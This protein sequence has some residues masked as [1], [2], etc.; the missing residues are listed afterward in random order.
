MAPD[1]LEWDTCLPGPEVDFRAIA[2]HPVRVGAEADGQIVLLC[3]DG[4]ALFVSFDRTEDPTAPGTTVDI[5]LDWTRVAGP[6]A[7]GVT[8]LV[9][10]WT[11]GGGVLQLAP[12]EPDPGADAPGARTL[13]GPEFGLRVPPRQAAV[14]IDRLLRL[15][16]R[17]A[18]DHR[19]EQLVW[20]G[21]LDPGGR[22]QLHRLHR[23]E[24]HLS[25]EPAGSV[26]AVTV[27]PD[28]PLERLLPGLRT[29]LAGR[30]HVSGPHGRLTAEL[31]AVESVTADD[32]SEQ[33]AGLVGGA[34]GRA[35]W[36]RDDS[37]PRPLW[38]RTHDGVTEWVAL[39]ADPGGCPIPL[40]V[41]ELRGAA[42]WVE[43][44][45][46]LAAPPSPSVS[47][48]VSPSSRRRLFGRR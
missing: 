21:G 42:C 23:N 48:S 4:P 32:G 8:P 46:L 27:A 45:E 36:A 28:S 38:R 11:A 22:V 25:L 9:V 39:H 2:G 14:W 24:S 40:D 26:D 30:S 44:G 37:T 6:P 17:F 13:G 41:P 19:P 29:R 15:P 18:L 3:R 33:A 12:E 35:G 5:T 10:A 47:P 20:L 7:S 31:Y 1:S 43:R 16:R 34:M